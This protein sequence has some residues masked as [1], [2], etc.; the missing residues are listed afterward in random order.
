[1][2]SVALLGTQHEQ[3]GLSS[4]HF[5]YVVHV[6]AAQWNVAPSSEKK[7]KFYNISSERHVINQ[8]ANACPCLTYFVN[9]ERDGTKRGRVRV[10]LDNNDGVTS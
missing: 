1:M 9:R 3:T 6:L 10:S 7:F 5:S 2:L 4:K 8:F